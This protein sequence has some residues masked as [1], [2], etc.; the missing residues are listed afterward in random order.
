VVDTPDDVAID[1]A[2]SDEVDALVDLW[3]DL[4]RGQR[5]HGSHLLADENRTVVRESVSRHVV[6]GGA[7]VAR[8]T[9]GDSLVGFVLFG[10]ETGGYEQDRDRGVVENIY[11]VPRRRGEGI[12]SALLAEAEAALA[13]AGAGVVALE[14]MADNEAARRFYRRHGYEPH[15]IELERESDTH[16][17]P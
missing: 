12:G 17:N 2:T 10:P 14:T 15:R 3:V 6:T 16:S 9:D 5:D 11:V 13:D 4:A 8:E 1:P 7:L